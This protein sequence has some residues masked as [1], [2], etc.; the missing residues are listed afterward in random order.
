MLILTR[1]QGILY[2]FHMMVSMFITKI[3]PDL[4][5][6][7]NMKHIDRNIY[8]FHCVRVQKDWEGSCAFGPL[9]LSL[10][11]MSIFSMISADDTFVGSASVI[12]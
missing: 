11:W 1:K 8:M 6:N 2:Y 9:G 3:E 4:T 7:T 10:Q 5:L 12:T